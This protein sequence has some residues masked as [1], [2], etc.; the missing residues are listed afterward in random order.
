MISTQV[1]KI[2]GLVR[3]RDRF[4]RRRQRLVGPDGQTLKALELLTE[5]YVLVQG[6]TVAAMGSIKGLKAVRKVV[7]D[8]MKR[9]G[10]TLH[11]CAID[12]TLYN[13]PHWVI[14]HR[15]EERAPH[16]QHKN[17]DDKTRACKGSSSRK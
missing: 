15:H 4:V 11:R 1:I 6:N 12:A 7:E 9:C 10:I 13:L 3:N 14:P 16:L 8:C 17:T 5:C 2:G